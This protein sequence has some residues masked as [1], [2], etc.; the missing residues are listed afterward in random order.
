LVIAAHAVP[1]RAILRAMESTSPGGNQALADALGAIEEG[2]ITS[3]AS[4][5][6]RTHVEES[7]LKDVQPH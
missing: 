6:E 3:C 2:A 1:V 4:H 7:R 5:V